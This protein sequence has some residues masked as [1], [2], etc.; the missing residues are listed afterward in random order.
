MW[1]NCNS[2]ALVDVR[3]VQRY[4][5]QWIAKARK[6]KK[7]DDARQRRV[8]VPKNQSKETD[9]GDRPEERNTVFLRGNLKKNQAPIKEGGNMM[10]C[11][12]KFGST[13]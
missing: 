4:V 6:G 2:S 12:E 9:I 7:N 5:K 11:L 13:Y 8:L 1:L 10:D 3:L